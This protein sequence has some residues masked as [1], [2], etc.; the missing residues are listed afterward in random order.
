[1]KKIIHYCWFGGNPKPKKFEYYKKTWQRYLPDFEIMEWNEKNFDIHCNKFVEEAYKNK[2]WAFV[3]DVARVYALYNYGGLYMDTD[4]EI[5]NNV[6]FLFENEISIG[7]ESNNFLSTAMIYVNDKHN[8]YIK[9]ILDFYNDLEFDEENVFRYANPKIFTKCFQKIGLKNN[10]D[11]QELKDGVKVYAKDVLDPK[12]YDGKDNN[13]TNNTCAIHHFDATWT[14]K[15]EKISIWFVRHK[16]D[17]MVKPVYHLADFNKKLKRHHID[18]LLFIF[19]QVVLYYILF[20]RHRIVWMDDFEKYFIEFIVILNSYIYMK[21][22]HDYK[23]KIIPSKKWL[24]L[25]IIFNLLISFFVGGKQIFLNDYKVV[26]TNLKSNVSYILLNFLV[27]PFVFNFL[28]L[29][30]RFKFHNVE[31]RKFGKKKSLIFFL[32]NLF[33]LSVVC[34]SFYP[35]NMTSDSIEQL[36][37]AMGKCSVGG[38]HPI[39]YTLLI[40]LMLYI[41]PVP[42]VVIIFNAIFLSL[43]LTRIFRYLCK[44]GLSIKLAYLFDL[45]FIFSI[46]TLS[47][48]SILWKDIPFTISMLWLTFE[49]YKISKEKQDYFKNN[50]NI[51]NFVIC[52]VFVFFFRVNG[53]VPCFF[54]ILYLLYF[55]KKY[56]MYKR[57][58]ATLAITIISI[59]IIKYPVYGLFS[60]NDQSVSVGSSLSF[61]TKG[62][63]AL[64]YYGADL[65]KEDQ[66]YLDTLIDK[67]YMVENYS[68]YNIDKISFTKHTMNGKKMKTGKTIYIY[69]KY[70]LKNPKIII[71]DRL[72]SNNLLWSYQTPDDGFLS[73]YVTGI[74]LPKKIKPETVNLGK[75]KDH[76]N[77]LG[78]KKEN[79][80]STA[81]INYQELS[82]HSFILNTIFW[83]FGL[84]LSILLLLIYHILLRKIKILPTLI[85]ISANNLFWIFLLSHQS[86]R[87]LW[88][89]S[90]ITY[91]IFIFTILEGSKNEQ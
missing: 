42:M 46:S 65:D 1:M 77:K 40:R 67:K 45:I 43:I 9:Q 16:M 32:V 62:L 59:L 2:K 49:L 3:S 86:Y 15:E 78:I 66:A 41:S 57:V 68:L 71:R 63:Y 28:V 91:F 10:S 18:S 87:Y 84:Y 14:P 52:M 54:V 21:K 30:N 29:L 69:L 36:C 72:D 81:I 79:F 25:L 90:V 61:V 33:I 73:S 85:P 51:L 8:K 88:Y 89:I 38:G 83:H 31:K 13:F 34:L 26:N 27:Y 37:Q 19:F 48:I 64:E 23:D 11:T 5:I 55:A 12:S 75:D 74:W 80:I 39:F 56:K 24:I 44:N 76:D 82:E 47:M 4:V 58:A 17:F 22:H 53:L 20:I 50:L 60:S 6:D 70:L 35:G 7:R